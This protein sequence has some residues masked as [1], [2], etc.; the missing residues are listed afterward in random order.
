[1]SFEPQKL[2]DNIHAMMHQIR[3]LKP[4]TSKGA[5]IKKIVLKGSMTPAVMLKVES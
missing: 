2:A 1:M 5:F 3:R 4:Q